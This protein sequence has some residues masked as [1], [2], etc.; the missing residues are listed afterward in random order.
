MAYD[1]MRQLAELIAPF[2]QVDS[3]AAQ[4]MHFAGSIV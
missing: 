4:S 2:G 3:Q 1:A